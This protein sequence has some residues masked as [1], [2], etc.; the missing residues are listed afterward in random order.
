MKVVEVKNIVRKDVPIYYRRLYSG[1]AVLELLSD[2]VDVPLDFQI[3]H[4]PTGQTEINLTL[5]EK[6]DYPLVSLQK[7]LKSFI[8]ALDSDGKLPV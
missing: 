7:E 1:I 5:H 3:E 2:K 6:V 4:M 8:G